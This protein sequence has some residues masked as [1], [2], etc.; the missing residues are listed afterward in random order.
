MPLKL[1]TQAVAYKMVL[2]AAPGV[3]AAHLEGLPFEELPSSLGRGA[4]F[5]KTYGEWVKTFPGGY[6]FTVRVDEKV[7][8]GSLIKAELKK[9]CERFEENEGFKPGRKVRNELRERVVE[10]LTAKALSRTKLITGFYHLPS[11]TLLVPAVSDKARNDF[12]GVLL[13]AVE[14][15]KATT[16]YVSTVKASLTTRLEATLNGIDGQFGEFFMGNKVVLAG[17]SGKSSFDLI[18]DLDNASAGIREAIAR[19]DLVKEIALTAGDDVTFRLTQDFALK[20]INFGEAIDI[21]EG[22]DNEFD[23]FEH[24]AAA[25]TSIVVSLVDALCQLF[26]YQPP[27]DDADDLI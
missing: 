11:Q 2:P 27:A 17:P 14:S 9:A 12:T 21:E 15:I 3:L 18:D 1:I 7:I 4:G 8:P 13:R 25:Q 5:V 6:A 16:I 10:T 23:E 22:Y 24:E 26:D 19:G 20:G